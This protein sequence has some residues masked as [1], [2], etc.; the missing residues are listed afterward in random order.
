MH[1]RERGIGAAAA[2]VVILIVLV[3][4]TTAYIVYRRGGFR[5]F[6]PQQ[7]PTA[8]ATS[9]STPSYSST[10]GASSTSSALSSSTVQTSSCPTSSGTT[11][12]TKSELPNAAV[13][14]GNFSLFQVD[15]QISSTTGPNV[16]HDATY[17]VVKTF[18]ANGSLFYVVD[19][20]DR[21]TSTSSGAYT[22]N[23]SLWLSSTGNTAYVNLNGVNYTGTLA[24]GMGYGVLVPVYF[25]L[26]YSGMAHDVVGNPNYVKINQTSETL[27]TVSV[28]FT[29][30][31]P[32][33]LPM[34]GC[35]ATLVAD[36]MGIGTVSGTN[37]NLVGSMFTKTQ[38]QGNVSTFYLKVVSLA[39]A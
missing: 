1:D 16:T 2:V 3:A 34:T 23:G 21:I 26:E 25:E 27:G 39:L 37:F 14:F 29:F 38:S 32:K 36:Q 18:S 6:T 22:E 19:F 12:V 35:G 7:P 10:S 24:N 31:E 15:L 28:V 5:S 4:G 33:D 8:T 11:T 30:Y 17:S 9:Y 13:I 20:T